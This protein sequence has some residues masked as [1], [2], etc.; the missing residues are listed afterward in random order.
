MKE[1]RY[2]FKGEDITNTKIELID[3]KYG[4]VDAKN[5]PHIE[6]GEATKYCDEHGF[7]KE[8]RP[9]AG[10]DVYVIENYLLP[11]GTMLCRYGSAKG[12][13]TTL[14]GTPYENLSLPY[15]KETIEYHEYKVTED[16]SVNC[17][18]TKGLVAPKFKS[19]GGAIQFMHKQTIGLECED[20][21][22]QEDFVWI[23]EVI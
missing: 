11:K 15:V 3:K 17:Y 6:W 13:F 20:G 23:Q 8:H 12:N 16:I 21:F 9:I 5:I 14:K 18:V 2:N 10:M 1:V 22:L 4:Y 19:S 7:D